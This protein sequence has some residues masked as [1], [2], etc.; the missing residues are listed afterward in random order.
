MD[1]HQEEKC[2]FGVAVSAS[3]DLPIEAPDGADD[4]PVLIVSGMADGVTFDVDERELERGEAGL[5]LE[6]HVS[7]QDGNTCLDRGA[8]V[9]LVFELE[10]PATWPDEMASDYPQ[11][12]HLLLPDNG[13]VEIELW[14]GWMVT[15]TPIVVSGYD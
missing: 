9:L 6:E 13:E 1:P 15:V 14:Q 2:L 10:I 8:Q 4:A 3:E 7:L 11:I 5:S 12:E